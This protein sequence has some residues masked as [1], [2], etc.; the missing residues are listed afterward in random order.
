MK[1]IVTIIV[2]ALIAVSSYTS[3][4]QSSKIKSPQSGGFQ[5]A[6]T[7]ARAFLLH[8]TDHYAG[9]VD[10]QQ[11][12]DQTWVPIRMRFSM[13]PDCL[14][15]N[16]VINEKNIPLPEPIAGIPVPDSGYQGF[17]VSIS[18]LDHNGALAS[19]GSF[20]T[21]ALFKG[22]AIKIALEPDMPS[23][24][25]PLNGT[26]PN[27]ISVQ[28]DGVD[29]WGWGPD[30]DYMIIQPGPFS[31]G[32]TY[33]VVDGNGG[34]LAWGRI[35]PFKDQVLIEDP[36]LN[37]VRAGGEREA[38]L[39]EYGYCW[40]SNQKFDCHVVRNGQAVAAKVYDVP[41]IGRHHLTIYANNLNGA[42]ITIKRPVPSGDMP[43]VP[44]LT[45]T[46]QYGQVMYYTKEVLD[47][48][49]VTVL[50]PI[51]KDSANQFQIQFQRSY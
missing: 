33:N 37:I 9:W 8:T 10:A 12:I 26:D 45:T 36:A 21:N 29:W 24:K 38:R 20:N 2:A 51:G 39:G 5:D 28:M 43:E 34:R 47:N 17:S 22:D 42:T 27:S 41:D 14:I 11:M 50:P 25:V 23:F 16:L 44:T 31:I 1:K 18:A 4:A 35:D 46:D 3:N 48:A 30:G 19:S 32:A 7:L 49:V 6:E 13:G 15:T 40:F